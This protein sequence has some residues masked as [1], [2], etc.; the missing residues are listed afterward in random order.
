MRRTT[1][2][3]ALAGAVAA[4]SGAYA[5]GTQAGG[6]NA[7]A[8]G[9]GSAT[10]AAA[11]GPGTGMAVGARRGDRHEARLG[12]LAQRLGVS[13]A[14]LRAALV[15]VRGQQKAQRPDRDALTQRLATARGMP[16]ADVQRVLDSFRARHDPLADF[17]KRLGVRTTTLRSTIERLRADG[18]RERLL[19]ALAR[20]LRI[21][22]AKVGAAVRGLRTE[23]RAGR[24]EDRADLVPALATGLNVDRA[25]V[26]SALTSLRRSF[27]ADAQAHFDAFAK[28]LA[29]QLGVSEEK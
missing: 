23:R 10:T 8:T 21:S 25:K 22:E 4:A 18:K 13:E 27:R 24:H 19:P 5:L 15:A 20:E 9:G 1:T 14:R 11:S 16:A 29:G 2:A 17:A 7:D 28:A 26:R 6:G 12:D 3:V